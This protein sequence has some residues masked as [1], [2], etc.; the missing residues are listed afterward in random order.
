MVPGDVTTPRTCCVLPAP[1]ARC[2][3]G[4][5]ESP[6]RGETRGWGVAVGL[7]VVRVCMSIWGGGLSGGTP[8]AP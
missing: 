3:Q 5:V 1:A 7:L 4:G 6:G 8:A 2:P